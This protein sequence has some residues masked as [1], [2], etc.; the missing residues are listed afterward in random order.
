[1]KK[2]PADDSK[3]TC[4]H[5]ETGEYYFTFFTASFLNFSIKKCVILCNQIGV[6][7]Y[8]TFY[9]TAVQ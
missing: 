5:R 8:P 1:M 4:V 7:L 2:V 3:L 6:A 9:H